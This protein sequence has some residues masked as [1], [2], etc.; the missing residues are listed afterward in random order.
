MQAQG[1]L[2]TSGDS[3]ASLGSADHESKKHRNDGG[4]EVC[5]AFL[6]GKCKR[7]DDCK[8]SHGA[9]GTASNGIAR[10]GAAPAPR[11]Q[12]APAPRA[13]QVSG[14]SMYIYMSV[15]DA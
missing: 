9:A 14:E 11:A 10:G 5:R 7:G 6:T 2:K 3:L 1:G 4:A 15:Y 13:L 8:F 12:K